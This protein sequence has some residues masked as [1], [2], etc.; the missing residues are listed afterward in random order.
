MPERS[1]ASHPQTETMSTINQAWTSRGQP[2]LKRPMNI[3]HTLFT[4]FSDYEVS[5]AKASCLLRPAPQALQ[6]ENDFCNFLKE[7]PFASVF[8]V[9]NKKGPV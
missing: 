6:T 5:K 4:N 8:M 9:K 2:K 3:H 7:A 1:T